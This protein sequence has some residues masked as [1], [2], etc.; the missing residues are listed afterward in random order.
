MH[1]AIMDS[2]E[3]EAWPW[4]LMSAAVCGLATLAG[5]MAERAG[6]PHNVA[7][8]LYAVAYLAGGWEAAIETY[9]KLRRLSLDIHFLMLAVA[10]G[11]ALIGAWWEGAALLFLF[12]LSGALEAMAMARTEREIRSL[13]REA[14]KQ[15]LLVEDG[16]TR[17]IPVGTLK[18][19]LTVR[20]LPGEQFPADG[21]VTKGESAVDE[22]TITGE[23]VPVDK[24]PGDTVFGGTLN[25]WGVL[26]AEITRAPGDSAND[27]IIRLIREAQ[28]SKAPSQRFTDRFGTTYTVGILSFSLVMFLWWHFVAGVPA[29]MEH[30]GK[31]AFYRAMTLL[32]VCSPCALVIS[33]PSAVLA[34]IAAGARRGILFRGGVAVENLAT[35]QRLAVDKTGTLTKGELELLDCKSETPGKEDELLAVAAALSENSTHPLSRAIVKESLRRGIERKQATEFESLAGQGLRAMVGG[36]SA[37]QGRRSMFADDSWLSA[38]PDPAPGLTEVLVKAG[39]LKGRLLLRDAPRSEA[40]PLIKQ[41]ADEGI[42]VTMLTGDREESARLVADELGLSDYRSGLHPEDKVAAIQAWRAQ[43]EIVAMAGDGVNDAPSLAAADISIGMG[44]RGSDAVLE[45]ADVV[46]TQ[47]RLERILDALQLSRRCRK[48]IRQN[49]AISLGVVVLLALAALGSWIP[50]PIGVLGHEGSTV[51]VVLNSLRLLFR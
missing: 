7:T 33:I 29:F 39:D 32:V 6:A 22:S 12:S 19:G 8:G 43:G 13:F 46:L 44:L 48:I 14:P 36:V 40:A 9:G 21:R 2:G 47:D 17:E 27:R 49:L 26:E 25:T 31:S 28:A 50:L 5:V 30:D 3:R 42:R 1:A 18:A 38:L 34:G 10:V 4:L 15:A 11:A 20:V 35:I 41:L 37:S 16:G 51:L 24:T 23:S 45:Q